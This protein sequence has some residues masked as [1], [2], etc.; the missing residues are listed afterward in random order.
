VRLARE[1]LLFAVGGVLGLL[2]DAAIV[3]VL[4]RDA[5]WDPYLARVPS[6]LVAASVTWWWNRHFSFAHRRGSSR[7]REWGR[8][9]A[10]MSVGAVV[11]YGIYAV[12]VALS[13]TVRAWPAAGVAAGSAVAA[14]INFAGARSV[15]FK[16]RK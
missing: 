16:A 10:V 1:I 8:W 11:N 5:S 6:F 13:A 14:V 4:V 2:V 9:I 15:V 12:L 3:Q 7:R